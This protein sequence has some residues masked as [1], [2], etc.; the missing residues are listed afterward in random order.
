MER[1]SLNVETGE[2]R[3]AQQQQI[4]AHVR[5]R[6]DLLRPRLTPAYAPRD[7]GYCC[8]GWSKLMCHVDADEA[9]NDLFLLGHEINPNQDIYINAVHFTFIVC[10][11]CLCR[12]PVIGTP[13]PITPPA[14]DKFPGKTRTGERCLP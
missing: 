10:G 4:E 6:I 1:P 12:C 9:L 11:E 5:Y 14:G 8:C 7:A 3:K 2:S 13:P